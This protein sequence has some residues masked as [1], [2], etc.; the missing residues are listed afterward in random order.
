MVT[1]DNR[2]LT[3]SR[4]I[5]QGRQRASSSQTRGLIVDAAQALFSE[6]GY[7][8]TSIEDIVVR[9]GIS[10]GSI[11]HHVGGKAA[12]FR[13]V[14]T[15]V[16]SEQAK[17]S[18]TAIAEALTSGERDAVELY[19]C[20]ASAYLMSAWRNRQ[21]SRVILSDDRPTGF[22]GVQEDLERRM[23][24][25]TRDIVLGN[26]PTQDLSSA[27][28]IALLRSGSEQLIDVADEQTAEAVI[29]YYIGLLRRLS[30]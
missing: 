5:P 25:G 7:E 15:Q 27:A 22:T 19:L 14:A 17:A 28:V 9:S 4:P 8:Q 2:E 6:V 13:E 20:G 24:A 10:V 29:A 23:I 16:I 30:S 18:H 1:A 3:N 12:I 26:P 21:V 11:Y